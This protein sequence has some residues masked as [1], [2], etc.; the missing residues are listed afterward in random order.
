MAAEKIGDEQQASLASLT[1]EDTSGAADQVGGAFELAS[2]DR[3]PIALR[4][5]MAQGKGEMRR[6]A[7]GQADLISSGRGMNAIHAGYVH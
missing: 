7:P 5:T 6:P 1:K 2:C 4:R 3:D